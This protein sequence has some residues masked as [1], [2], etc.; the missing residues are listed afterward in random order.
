MDKSKVTDTSS[1]GP[2]NL[3]LEQL[4]ELDKLI[5][6]LKKEII[7]PKSKKEDDKSALR[8]AQRA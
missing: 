4:Q 2:I 5:N 6:N 3:D 8:S 1:A 7:F